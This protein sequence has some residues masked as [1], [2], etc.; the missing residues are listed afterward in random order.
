MKRVF[1]KARCRAHQTMKA[2]AF[3]LT[4]GVAAAALPGWSIF[5]YIS[6]AFSRN[7]KTHQTK[8]RMHARILN[9]FPS[10]LRIGLM[11]AAALLTM[12]RAGAATIPGLFNTGVDSN[13]VT[14]ANSAIDPHYRLIQSADGSAPGPSTASP[15]SR[16]A[17]G[18]SRRLSATSSSSASSTF[19]RSTVASC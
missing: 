12:G 6:G 16:R 4:A 9:V 5:L 3:I 11:A 14:L 17:T 10:S 1:V 19:T 8:N 15:R 7:I 2:L 18:A 13:G